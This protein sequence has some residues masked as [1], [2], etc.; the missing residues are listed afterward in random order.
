M[1]RPERA[2]DLSQ[3]S[4]QRIL[5]SGFPES[6]RHS[7]EKVTRYRAPDEGHHVVF[8][9]DTKG[10]PEKRKQRGYPEYLRDV[11]DLNC[12]GSAI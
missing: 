8:L 6:D 7:P 2:T 11:L 12:A 9:I 10:L 3:L 1:A 5:N 4:S